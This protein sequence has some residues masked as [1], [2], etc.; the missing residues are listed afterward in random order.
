MIENAVM[1]LDRTDISLAS[2]TRADPRAS[3]DVQAVDVK[4]YW[5]QDRLWPAPG[6][7]GAQG[8]GRDLR[9]QVPR[10]PNVPRLPRRARPDVGRRRVK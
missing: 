10:L 5:T 1:H 7:S 4:N 6:S 8:S 9:C 2:T 3:A